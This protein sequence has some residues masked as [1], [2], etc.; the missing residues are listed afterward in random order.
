MKQQLLQ[1]TAWALQGHIHTSIIGNFL[2]EKILI[3]LPFEPHFWPRH[4]LGKNCGS[5][6]QKV[7]FK[8]LS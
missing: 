3:P 4:A 8:L 1:L 7:L 2:L 5:S 6:K